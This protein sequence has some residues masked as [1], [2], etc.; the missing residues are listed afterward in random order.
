MRILVIITSRPA[1]AQCC[2][3]SVANA[4]CVCRDSILPIIQTADLIQN[5][6]DQ[7]VLLEFSKY[8]QNSEERLLLFEVLLGEPDMFFTESSYQRCL[9]PLA[10]FQFSNVNIGVNRCKNCRTLAIY[11]CR[12][13]ETKSVGGTHSSQ[14]NYS[15]CGIQTQNAATS[16]L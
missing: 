12:R 11:C 2:S 8:S 15:Y 3:C 7:M 14:L 5:Y 4:G 10:G 16:W 6:L 9:K 13:G 1:P